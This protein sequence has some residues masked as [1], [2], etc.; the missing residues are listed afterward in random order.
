MQG[1]S[2]IGDLS[3]I[4]LLVL[5]AVRGAKGHPLHA[6]VPPLACG[7]GFAAL[8]A[9]L[10]A[11]PSFGNLLLVVLA[12]GV[13]GTL[14]AVA[15]TGVSVARIPLVLTGFL[16]LYGLVALLLS[17]AVTDTGAA[18]WHARMAPGDV[19]RRAAAMI[20][21]VAGSLVLGGGGVLFLQR[22]RPARELR[23]SSRLMRYPQLGFAAASV[24]MAGLFVVV[25]LPLAFWLSTSAAMLAGAAVVLPLNENARWP[26]S[27][28]LTALC[29]FATAAIGFALASLLL[30]IA[31]GL[32]GASMAAVFSGLC[33]EARKRPFGLLFGSRD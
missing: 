9:I 28:L 1:L 12:L 29:G 18:F 13:G 20:A 33:R 4:V 23:R 24:L 5:S 6:I 2:V 26:L 16:V 17:S 11:Q 19:E 8:A 3:A 27:V 15:A 30:I 25:N 14:G 31:G 22:L 10:A 32:V 21:A 7:L